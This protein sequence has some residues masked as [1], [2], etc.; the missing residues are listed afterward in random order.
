MNLEELRYRRIPR[1]RRPLTPFSAGLPGLNN[2]IPRV[3]SM[4]WLGPKPISKQGQR[5]IASWM[6]HHPTWDVTVWCDRESID[7]PRLQGLP[8]KLVDDS[9]FITGPLYRAS[10]NYGE[11]TDVLR[12]ELAR[13]GCVWVDCDVECKRP[14]DELLAVG[15]AFIG[16]GDH[17]GYLQ[18]ENAVIGACAGHP[19]IENALRALPMW[20]GINPDAA[21]IYKT[22]PRY[23]DYQARLL[24]GAGFELRRTGDPVT[25]NTLTLHPV[26]Y[27]YAPT[28]EKCRYGFHGWEG[29][30]YDEGVYQ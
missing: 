30:W 9:D 16:A 29:T 24:C 23:L 28:L 19:F 27:W 1:E 6:L 8:L 7:Q 17:P 12:L 25:A 4:A 21:T 13:R 14:I 3:L 5:C 18:I 11:R 20:W 15:G 10:V 22:G 26:D 2:P